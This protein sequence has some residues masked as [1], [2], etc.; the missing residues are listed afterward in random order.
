M[1]F[2]S[3]GVGEVDVGT[4]FLPDLTASDN[5]GVG[6]RVS[7]RF[8]GRQ[9]L[10]G[11]AQVRIRLRRHVALFLELVLEQEK[12]DQVDTVITPPP[13]LSSSE[14]AVSEE[15]GV[16][17]LLFGRLSSSRDK[18]FAT[19]EMPHSGGILILCSL[20]GAE[21]ADTRSHAIGA[22]VSL[23]ETAR[24]VDVEELPQQEE[25]QQSQEDGLETSR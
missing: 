8:G 17:S 7:L 5:K 13:P 2:F 20:L 1:R 22:V 9:I 3:G 18:C 15:S 6:I 19:T 16:I 21:D 11:G 14:N 12:E 23:M 4:T 10:A 24:V 25:G